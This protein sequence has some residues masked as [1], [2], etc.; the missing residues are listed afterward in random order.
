LSNKLLKK[1][2]TPQ[3][4]KITNSITDIAGGVNIIRQGGDLKRKNP[5]VEFVK[6]FA[7]ENNMGYSQA[8]CNPDCK[9]KY[10]KVKGDGIGSSRIQPT[11]PEGYFLQPVGENVPVSDLDFM[12]F[13]HR[14]DPKIGFMDYFSPEQLSWMQDREDNL[15]QAKSDDEKKI[16]DK[17]N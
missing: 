16:K 4:R 1:N 5:W 2:F 3:L 17:K 8:L 13:I 9:F 6:Q 14:N 12:G 10:R 7:Q 15:E 11:Q